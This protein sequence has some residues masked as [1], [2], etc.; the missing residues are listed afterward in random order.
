MYVYRTPTLLS[1]S[2]VM[3]LDPRFTTTACF[4][5]AR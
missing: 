2:G 4:Q 1:V 5:N 3:D